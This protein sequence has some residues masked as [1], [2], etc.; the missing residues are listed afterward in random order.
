MVRLVTTGGVIIDTVVA[1]DGVL[2]PRTMG[3]NAVYSAAGARLWLDGVAIVGRV[4]A[5][6]PRLHIDRVAAAGVDVEGIHFEAEP[7]DAGEWFFY[8]DDGSRAD[9]LHGDLDE[10]LPGEPGT[11]LS[12]EVRRALE[13]RLA[14]R[15]A[16]GRDFADFRRRHPVRLADL[17]AHG[18]AAGAVHLA[19]NGIA[20]QRAMLGALARTGRLVSVDPG[21]NAGHY[22]AADL[23][24]VMTEA[25]AFLPSEKELAAL[26]PG[27]GRRAAFARIA[28]LGPARLVVKLGAE[29]S[30]VRP[31]HGGDAVPLPSLAV[32]VRDPTGAGDAF[33]GGFLA[34]LLLT[35][36]ALAAAVLATVSA[37]FAVE[38]FGPFHLLETSGAAGKSRLARFVDTL[39]PMLAAHVRRHLTPLDPS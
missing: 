20:E 30:L 15:P 29:G 25:T 10:P 24:A 6:Y 12:P 38:A 14:A 1:A 22:S 31:D 37:S 21:S 5:N 36:D 26:E 39:E 9:H 3:G 16:G 32:A 11:R 13:E 27:L 7:V 28:A 33:C 8:R 23:T 17:P 34:G 19:A 4:P 35:G 18:A 2:G